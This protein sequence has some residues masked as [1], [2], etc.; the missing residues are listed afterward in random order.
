MFTL[1]RLMR[2]LTENPLCNHA[3]LKQIKTH[4]CASFKFNLS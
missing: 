2:I 4:L 3:D 1:Q